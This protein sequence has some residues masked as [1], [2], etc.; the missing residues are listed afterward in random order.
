[1]GKE[2]G[3]IKGAREKAEKYFKIM[4]KWNVYMIYVSYV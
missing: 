1:M 3:G 4:D 2:V